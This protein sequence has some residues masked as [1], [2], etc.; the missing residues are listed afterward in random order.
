MSYRTQ[1]LLAEDAFITTRVTACAAREGENDPRRFALENKWKLSA[2]PGWD[3]AY[4]Y[5]IDTGVA[6]PGN[7][8]GVIND[9]MILA[10]VQLLRSNGTNPPA[11]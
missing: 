8:E 1:A 2:Q 6:N 9:A 5:A 10:A 7:E 3:E 11:Q 4:S